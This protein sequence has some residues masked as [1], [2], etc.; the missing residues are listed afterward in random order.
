MTSEDIKFK[1]IKFKDLKKDC[2]RNKIINLYANIL[3]YIFINSHL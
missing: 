3:A 1:D 2:I